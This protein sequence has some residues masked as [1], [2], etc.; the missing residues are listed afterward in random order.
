MDQDGTASRRQRRDEEFRRGLYRDAASGWIMTADLLAGILAW[1]G[2]GWLVDRWL[3]TTP[4]LLSA[5]IMVGFALGMYL[6]IR[7]AD[8][9]DQDGR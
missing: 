2:I 4:W 1:G 7:R 3:G 8:A 5:G 9:A 6:V